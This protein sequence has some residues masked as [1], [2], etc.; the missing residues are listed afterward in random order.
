M[1]GVAYQVEARK[2][3]RSTTISN[4]SAVRASGERARYTDSNSS[5]ARRNGLVSPNDMVGNNISMNKVTSVELYT[6]ARRE[7]VQQTMK[8]RHK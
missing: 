5:A 8:I 3:S 2:N 7:T 1:I 4:Y 6:L